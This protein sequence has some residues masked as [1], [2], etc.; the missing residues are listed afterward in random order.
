MNCEKAIGFCCRMIWRIIMIAISLQIILSPSIIVKYY[1]LGSVSSQA[2]NNMTLENTV[3]SHTGAAREKRSGP[4][5]ILEWSFLKT[6]AYRQCSCG[7]TKYHTSYVQCML[8]KQCYRISVAFSIS[9]WTGENYSSTLRV[10]TYLF[11]N[12]YKNLRLQKYP[13]TCGRGLTWCA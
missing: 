10:E 12:G 4:H 8:C 11:L 9:E 6:L 3:R 7:R 13:S 1:A 5:K 2:M